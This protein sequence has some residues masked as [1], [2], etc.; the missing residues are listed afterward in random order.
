M[1]RISQ[2]LRH[3]DTPYAN[4]PQ[5]PSGPVPRPSFL[6]QWHDPRKLVQRPWESGAS[7]VGWHC[8]AHFQ[9]S[10]DWSNWRDAASRGSLRNE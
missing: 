4:I 6:R 2:S 7:I 8:A 5:G 10:I 1:Q 3:L 9:V